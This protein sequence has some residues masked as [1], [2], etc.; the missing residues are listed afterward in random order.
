M[1]AVKSLLL[2]EPL[3]QREK[4]RRVL[5]YGAGTLRNTRYL[6][7][8]G[9]TVY[10]T[11]LP[12]Q[13]EKVAGQARTSGV[14]GILAVDELKDT[15]LCLDLVTCNFVFNIIEDER[16]KQRLL[17]NVWRNLRPGGLFLL[18][19]AYRRPGSGRNTLTEEEIE[20]RVI[21]AGFSRVAV[22]CRGQTLTVLFRR[23][24]LAATKMVS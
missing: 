5:D 21:P 1:A 10:I 4:V 12:A 23:V 6:L 11:D 15:S 19:V 7:N 14:K 9:Y 8:R 13:L 2:L 22:I 18:D 17:S 3:F 16:E 20:A 24:P